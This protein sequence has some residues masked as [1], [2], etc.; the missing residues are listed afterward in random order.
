MRSARGKLGWQLGLSVAV[1]TFLYLH[2]IEA[3]L[4]GGIPVDGTS[5]FIPIID[6][7]VLL[8]PLFILFVA[9][10]TTYVYAD[11]RA[12]GELEER[13]RVDELPAEVSLS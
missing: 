12:R 3:Q 7:A 6:G 9:L 10:V 4:P 2:P 5:L 8:G 1:G 13:T 11:A